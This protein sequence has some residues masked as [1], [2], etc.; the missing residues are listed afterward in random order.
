VGVEEIIVCGFQFISEFKSI[1][2]RLLK[3]VFG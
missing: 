1:G 3:A 2:G